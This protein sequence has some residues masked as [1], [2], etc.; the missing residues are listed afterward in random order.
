MIIHGPINY[1][2]D[3]DLGPVLLSDCRIHKSSSELPTNNVADFHKDYF[4]VVEAGW[5]FEDTIM[6]LMS[7]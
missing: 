2:Y 5:F 3:I 6:P 7:H 4:E 1:D